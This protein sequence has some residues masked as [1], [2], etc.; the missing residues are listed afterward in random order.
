MILFIHL[1]RRKSMENIFDSKIIISY[2][3]IRRKRNDQSND[4]NMNTKKFK[5]K[6]R[7]HETRQKKT[8]K[9]KH[10]KIK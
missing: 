6:H 8:Y 5:G 3:L 1:H 7:E 10:T 9:I 4:I 2:R